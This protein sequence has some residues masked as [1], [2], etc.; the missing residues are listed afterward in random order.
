MTRAEAR[1]RVDA[2]YRGFG[3][4]HGTLERMTALLLRIEAESLERAARVRVT[5]AHVEFNRAS[6]RAGVM[7][8]RTAIRKRA[9]KARKAAECLRIRP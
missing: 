7:D 9:A 8:T 4:G 6:W 3:H 5:Q 2:I 1:E